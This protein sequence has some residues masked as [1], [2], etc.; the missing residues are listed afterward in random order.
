MTA[1]FREKTAQLS[2]EVET[3]AK[4]LASKES[5][6]PKSL[7]IAFVLPIIWW[8]ILYWGQPW[9]IRRKENGREVRD[10]G[11]VFMWTILF[12]MI[13]WLAMYLYFK[14]IGFNKA[15]MLCST[16]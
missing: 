11:K 9:F 8:V 16:V 1:N 12:T 7:I 14:F 15:A 13:S 2:E 3:L 10:T 5:C 4:R 6:F